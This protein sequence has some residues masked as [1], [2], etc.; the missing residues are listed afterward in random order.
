MKFQAILFGSRDTY[1]LFLDFNGV[2]VQQFIFT[3]SYLENY[4]M[5]CT[6]DR[7]VMFFAVGSRDAT[8]LYIIF[9]TVHRYQIFR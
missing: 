6:N 8:N 4:F 3:F 9:L 5:R 7:D 2:I 1:Q